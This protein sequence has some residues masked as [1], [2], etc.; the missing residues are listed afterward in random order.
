MEVGVPFA[1]TDA[2]DALKKILAERRKEL[3]LRG[4]RWADLRRLNKEAAFKKTLTRIINGTI[5]TLPPN[6]IKYAVPIPLA[7]FS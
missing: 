3:I 2:N 6:D 4:L 1:A 5:Y 7:K